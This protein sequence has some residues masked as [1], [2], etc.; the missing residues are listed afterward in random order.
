MKLKRLL[1]ALL[2]ALLL[3][4]A[5]PSAFMVSAAGDKVR[6]TGYATK[7]MGTNGGLY[8]YLFLDTDIQNA[9]H[10]QTTER[11]WEPDVPEDSWDF[12]DALT[13][14]ARRY[15]LIN[16][17]PLGDYID[18]IG[19]PWATVF[20]FEKAKDFDNKQTLTIG[21]DPVAVP[22][23][24]PAKDDYVIEIKTGMITAELK[25]L[26]ACTLS[27]DHTTQKLTIKRADDGGLTLDE[28]NA[29]ATP[30]GNTTTQNTTQNT[31]TKNT[32]TQNTTAKDTTKNTTSTTAEG[33][34]P[35]DTTD[36]SDITGDTTPTTVPTQDES[37][38]VGLVSG[39]I[40][41]EDSGIAIDFS[42][43]RITLDRAMVISDFM[44]AMQVNSA[45]TAGVYNGPN[46]VDTSTYIYTGYKF[47]VYDGEALIGN[48]LLEA[49]EPSGGIP[50]WGILLIVVGVLVLAGGGVAA[51]LIIRKKKGGA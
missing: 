21:L 6:I 13:D 3:C 51:F 19:S 7:E 8:L 45:Y 32:T 14:A 42:G 1:S 39:D 34:D 16:D 5:L 28:V 38:Q 15:I 17:M 40:A 12:P 22:G 37:V 29:G 20:C 49:P 46:E 2:C 31:T 33:T 9:R 18:A 43:S 50:W 23:V 24:D 25:R 10:F 4:G 27:W 26:E 44:E 35:T 47:K 48:F 11:Q 36:T 41:T 30:G